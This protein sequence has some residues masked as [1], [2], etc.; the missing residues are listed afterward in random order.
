MG[1]RKY[2]GERKK[3]GEAYL[4]D[5]LRV[6]KVIKGLVFCVPETGR[7]GMRAGGRGGRGGRA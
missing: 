6:P 1:E 7:G 2:D 3:E 4:R 5:D